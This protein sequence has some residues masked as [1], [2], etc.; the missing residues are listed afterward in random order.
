MFAETGKEEEEAIEPLE[1]YESSVE[2]PAGPVGYWGNSS[3]SEKQ[4]TEMT[5]DYSAFKSGGAGVKQLDSDS[6]WWSL[7]CAKVLKTETATQLFNERQD[8]TI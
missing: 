1:S 8:M 7:S 5:W 3:K 6:W 4:T 2:G